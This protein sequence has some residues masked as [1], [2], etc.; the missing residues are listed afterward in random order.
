VLK[1]R[2]DI[3]TAHEQGLAWIATGT[4]GA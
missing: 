2:D 3:A 1:Y 4:A